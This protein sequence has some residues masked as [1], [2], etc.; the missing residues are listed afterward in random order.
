MAIFLLFL[1]FLKSC[2]VL[3]K[4]ERHAN[5]RTYWTGP[6]CH[7]ENICWNQRGGQIAWIMIGI[8]CLC[9]SRYRPTY[10]RHGENDLNLILQ[11][12]WRSP[13]LMDFEIL[14]KPGYVSQI[15]IIIYSHFETKR[16]K[17]NA[18]I[19]V[20]FTQYGSLLL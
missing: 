2:Y 9:L 15:K 20:S 8:I 5:P 1:I 13:S 12:V 3:Q 10:D 17:L 6:L 4:N 19:N 7:C 18:K 16:S 14:H 11:Y